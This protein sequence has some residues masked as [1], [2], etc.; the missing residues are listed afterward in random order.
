MR[1]RLRSRAAASSTSPPQRAYEALAAW[2]AQCLASGE[3]MLQ[4]L[5]VLTCAPCSGTAFAAAACCFA[6][7]ECVTEWRWCAN[8]RATRRG[9]CAARGACAGWH[10]L[11]HL[12]LL[13]HPGTTR[14]CAAR[15]IAAHASARVGRAARARA[16]RAVWAAAR[17]RCAETQLTKQRGPPVD[18]PPVWS[19]RAAD[20]PGTSGEGG[21][22][23][24]HGIRA[25]VGDGKGRFGA[26]QI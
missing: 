10:L 13:V 22:G 7:E 8:E 21:G 26:L 23:I 24:G 9:A 16:R 4:A 17:A 12:G 25:E 5:S 2:A 3:S 6:S 20:S 11:T 19:R 18:A 1:A 15:I 14:S